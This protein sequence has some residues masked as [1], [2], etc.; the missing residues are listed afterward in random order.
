MTKIS[1]SDI[2]ALVLPMDRA[3]V[4]ARVA[5]YSDAATNGVVI[6]DADACE[7]HWLLLNEARINRRCG[8][9]IYLL[10]RAG[11]ALAWHQPATEPGPDGARQCVLPGAER[12]SGAA[13]ARRRAD[14]P[15]RPN[16]PQR[17]CDHGLFG[18]DGHL[19]LDFLNPTTERDTR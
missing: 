18:A 4:G 17:P 14:M 2:P 16:T 10:V 3:L 5:A 7:A 9:D 1:R 12:A 6:V 19:Q 11:E 15:L 8:F 13:M